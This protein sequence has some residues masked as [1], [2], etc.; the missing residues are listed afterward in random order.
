MS[1]NPIEPHSKPIVGRAHGGA[2]DG[3]TAAIP[4][5]PRRRLTWPLRGLLAASLAVP[6]LLLALAAWQNF[7]LVQSQAEERVIIEAGE[8]DEHDLS[9]F[10][11]YPMVLAWVD[12]RIRGREWDRV[13][14]DADFHRFL[15]DL[16]TLQQIDAIWIADAAGHIRAGDGSSPP[17]LTQAWPK[18]THSPL[19]GRVAAACLSGANTSIL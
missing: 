13:G 1:A 12:A 19:S 11:I 4:Q 18:T 8:L 15:A 14:H 17:Q 10:K 9:A 5:R 2:G 7:R 6:A 16:E 3:R